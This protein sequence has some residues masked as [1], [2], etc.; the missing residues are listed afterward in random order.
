[1][2]AGAVLEASGH[3][4]AGEGETRPTPRALR[5]GDA[6]GLFARRKAGA[7]L[8]VKSWNPYCLCVKPTRNLS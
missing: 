7:F 2:G 6:G 3:E 1:M 5:T 8:C 4:R